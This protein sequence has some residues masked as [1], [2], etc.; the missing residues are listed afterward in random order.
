MPTIDPTAFS[1]ALLAWYDD[2]HRDLPWRVSP[3]DRAAGRKPDPYRVWLSEVMLQQ[4]TVAAVKAYFETFTRRWPQIANLA[5]AP[6]S[7]VLSAWAGLGYYARARNLHA[8]ARTVHAAYGD[9]FPETAAA[10]KALPG[11]GDYTSAAIAAIA[12]D[13]PAAVVDGNVE[14]VIT[15]L[16][17]LETPLPRAKPQIRH[18]AEQLTPDHR[19]G[20]FAQ[21]MMDLGAMICTP[22]R[23]ACGICPVDVFCTA[24]RTA[25]AERFP[26]KEKKKPI[27]ERSG[28]AFV[29]FRRDG[30]VFLRQRPGS[31]MLG[32]MSEP[33]S[34]DWSART[35]GATGRDAAP[36]SADW[37][38]AGTIEHG[39]THFRLTL[40]VW[41]ADDVAEA[42]VGGRVA[43]WWSGPDQIDGEALPTVMKKVLKAATRGRSEASRRRKT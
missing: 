29:A 34:T 18:Q 19:P 3:R 8:C 32:G 11:V 22:R 20:D 4:T 12:F 42:A 25:K 38:Q 37:Q 16:I 33:P 9:R 27:P 23:P 10:L 40:E 41:R 21:A 24:T 5:Q 30:A 28:A 14:R 36:F 15:R 6:E 43:G 26:I 31:G 1:T 13:E 35:D 39:F 7:D 2:H 17:A